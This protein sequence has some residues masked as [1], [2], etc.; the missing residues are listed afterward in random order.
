MEERKGRI[1]DVKI[2]FGFF[3]DRIDRDVFQPVKIKPF[4]V[5]LLSCK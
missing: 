2:N 1:K 5:R 4:L 3:G